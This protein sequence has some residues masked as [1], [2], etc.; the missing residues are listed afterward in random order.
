MSS[1]NFGHSFDETQKLYQKDNAMWSAFSRVFGHHEPVAL[2]TGEEGNG[3]GEKRKLIDGATPSYKLQN[4]EGFDELFH[5]LYK[6]QCKVT[7]V[8]P[9]SDT[10]FYASESFHHFIDRN[11]EMLKRGTSKAM[12]TMTWLRQD[13][14]P[15]E[16]FWAKEVFQA[17]VSREDAPALLATVMLDGIDIFSERR[18]EASSN[19]AA[20]HKA[21][22]ESDEGLDA[23]EDIENI[24]F[25]CM[26]MILEKKQAAPGP[27]V[28]M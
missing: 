24:T 1:F 8:A 6:Q 26:K 14:M 16:T 2:E 13:I 22:L 3:Y 5:E 9:I 11:L 12:A 15:M 4:T 21:W 20:S 28:S 27:D 18:N 25:R 10:A 23:K 7:D 17:V 19:Y